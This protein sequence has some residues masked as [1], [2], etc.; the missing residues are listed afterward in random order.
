MNCEKSLVFFSLI[1]TQASDELS[2]ASDEP[3]HYCHI[4][5]SVVQRLWCGGLDVG[6]GIHNS[7]TS[8]GNI[9]LNALILFS[10]V[11]LCTVQKA[12]ANY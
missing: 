11:K 4:K 2:Q 7:Y 12:M 5:I 1:S 10:F 8:T 3:V 6:N 9:L